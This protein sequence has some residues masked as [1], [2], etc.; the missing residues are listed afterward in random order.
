MG[1]LPLTGHRGI[2]LA[3]VREPCE[4]M[5]RAAARAALTLIAD[6]GKAP[7]IAPIPGNELKARRSTMGSGH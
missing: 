4:E 3:T 6:P 1:D 7:L 5:G 2:S